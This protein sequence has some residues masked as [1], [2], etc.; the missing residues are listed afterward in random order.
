[1]HTPKLPHLLITALLIGGSCVAVAA[2][3]GPDDRQVSF[4]GAPGTNETDAVSPVLAFDSVNQ[5]YLLVW[6][7]DEADGDFLI[8]GQLLSGAAGAPV[9]PAFAISAAGPSGTDHRQPTVVF[10]P[11]FN[12]YLV[13]WASD[14]L[15]TG[16]NEIMGQLV[17]TDG[18]LVGPMRRY[19][20]MGSVDTD[21]AF[22]AVTPDLA[23][24]PFLEVFTVVWAADDDLGDLSDGRF[25]VYGQLVEGE[26]GAETGAND[27]RITYSLADTYGN[28]VL[29]PSVAVHP[30]SDRWFVA[31]EGDIQDDSIHE[32]EIWMYGCTGDI[33]DGAAVGLSLTGAN[34][35]DDLSAHNPDLAWIPS[36]GELVCV[37]DAEDDGSYPQGIYGR[38]IDP[39]GTLLDPLLEFSAGAGTPFGDL[40]EATHPV[41]TVD[42]LSDEWFVAWRGDLNDGLAH[43][44]HEVW[45]RRFNDVGSPVDP[46]AFQLSG[47]DPSLGPVAGA[48]APAVAINGTHGYKL[49]AWSGDLDSTPGD[50]HEIF[51]QAWSDNGTSPVD[52]TPGA[53]AFGLHGAAPNPFNP[54]TTIAFDLPAAAPVSLTIYDA[55]GRLVR[56]L[57][58]SGPGLAGR[59]E[60]VWNGRDDTGRQVSSG[61]YLYRLETTGHSGRGRMT[62]VK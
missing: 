3:L 34:F 38:R 18:Q 26:T 27:F 24:H 11:Q 39:D 9:A 59:N 37:W 40:R 14:V 2:N 42:P 46:A 31:F 45:A 41:I 22:D 57:L 16:A 48:G 35:F 62:L 54:S 13:V 7:A 19:S 55:S 61:V 36:S 17:G 12:H 5:R 56:K 6:S 47:M 33:P 53:I 25:E 23:W 20:D 49:I 21:T 60:A 29:E 15:N 44:D 28:D 51:V 43:F 52:E 8:H 30:G 4:T 1:M 10:S 58:N 50:E 32:P